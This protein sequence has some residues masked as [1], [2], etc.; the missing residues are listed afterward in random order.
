M[1]KTPALE[2]AR[3]EAWR[4]ERARIAES[5]KAERLRQRQAEQGK[6]AEE[7]EEDRK[8]AAVEFLRSVSA[9]RPMG[10]E[11]DAESATTY[12]TFRKKSKWPLFFAMVVAPMFAAAFYL[13]AIATPLYEAQSVIAITKSSDAG[14]GAQAGLLGGMGRPS[15]LSEVFRADTY[16]KSQA[17]MD[18]LEAEMGL[19]TDFSGSAIDPIRRLR[20]IPALSLSKHMQFDRFVESSIDVQS[21]LLTLYV[22]APSEEQAISVSEAVLRNAEIQ[23]SKLGEQLFD[24]RQSLAADVR[25][26]AERQVADAQAA[27][28]ALQLKYQE[29]D[30]RIRVENTYSRIK[31]LEDEAQRLKSEIQAAQ[32]AGVGNS[33][34]IGTATELEASLREQIAEERSKLVA[35]NGTST[36]PLNNLLMEYELARLNVDLAREAVKTAIE[37]Q[38][39]AGQEAAL[40]RSLFQVVVPPGTAQNAIYPKI[41]GILALVF[42]ICL[43]AYAAVATL[44]ETRA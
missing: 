6:A 4:A 14:S 37:A 30:P 8:T 31:D 44:R 3:I 23:V 12:R 39:K 19:V 26:S 2:E 35:P 40:D 22:R 13:F 21:G 11:V 15:N 36:T 28:V 34:R 27:L 33:T 18:T 29:V 9:V 17:L 43:T 24:N 41:P 10:L 25:V 5:D 42:L 16:I 20:T 7:A 1:T 32:I 38:A